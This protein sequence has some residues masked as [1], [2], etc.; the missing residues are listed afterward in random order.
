MNRWR[1]ICVLVLS[2]VFAA[3]SSDGTAESTDPAV[4]ETTEAA[5]ATTA[6]TTPVFP[7]RETAGVG[8]DTDLTPWTGSYRLSENHDAGME[9]I[10]GKPCAVFDGL[11]V[12]FGTSG[13]YLYV[14]VA[15]AIFR[16]SR[17]RTT[18]P[19][20]N[21]SAL[22][23]QS[24]ENELLIIDQC[25]FDGGPTHQRGVQADYGDVVVTASEF[26]RF[27][28]A[29]VEMNDRSATRSFT[30][31]DNY[32]EETPGWAYGDHVDGLQVGAGGAITIRHNTILVVAYG[33]REGD[34]TFVS[35]SAIGL[36]AEAGDVAG[37]VVVSG[38]LLAG[39][40]RVLYVEEK[41]GYKFLGSVTIS[42]NV[43]DRRYSPLGGIW[44]VVSDEGRPDQLEWIGNTFEDAT[45]ID[46]PDPI[47]AASLAPEGIKR[48]E[49]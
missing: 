15:C 21:T 11:D 10:D 46:S 32:L 38:N 31:T 37:P 3:C 43:I 23:Q 8:V 13:E 45:P 18:G 17:F 42:D 27:G 25:E 48:S 33:G 29:A 40:G 12:D 7:T 14:D 4:A 2:V 35:N 20:S 39:G 1:A 41:D 34:T 5:R 16:N 28:N 9:S 44:G 26:A 47:S 6:A 30:V 36:W 22:V 24:S 19:V 49:T